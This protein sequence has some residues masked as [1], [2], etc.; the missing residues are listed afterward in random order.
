[1]TVNAVCAI[2]IL[3]SG[4]DKQRPYFVALALLNVI[5]FLFHWCS[6]SLH[7]ATNV[8]DAV[9]I[10]KLHLL[11]IILGHPFLILVLGLW[12]RFKYVNAL[13]YTWCLLSLPL[14]F[15]NIFSDFS[16]RYGENVELV[17]YQTIFGDYASVLKGEGGAYFP[18]IHLSYGL[19]SLFMMYC[20]VRFFKQKQTYLFGALLLTIILQFG[21]SVVGFQIDQQNLNW[22][23]VGGV[24]ST[25][26]SLLVLG[27][28]SRGFKEKSNELVREFEQKSALQHV[29][30]ELAQI[31]NEDGQHAFY[32]ESVELLTRYTKADYVLFG[33]VDANDAQKI[34]T[35]VAFK[36]GVRIE[37]FAYDR[38]G[39]PCEN[40]LSIDA[41]VH[42][43]HVADDYPDDAFLREEGIEAYIGYPIVGSKQCT[44]GVLV[45][46]YKTPLQNDATVKTVTDVFAT[47]ISAEIRRQILQDELRAT[48]YIDYLTRLPNRIKLLRFINNIRSR[49]YTDH[50]QALLMLFDIDH[51]GEVNRKYG[52]DVGDRVLKV[53]GD[54]LQSYSNEGVFISRCGGDEFAVVIPDIKADIAKV[55]NVHWTAI[56]AIVSN[57]C[58]IGNRRININ[59]TM[60]AVVFPSQLDSSFDVIGA[61]EQAMMVSKEQGRGRFSFFDPALLMDVEHARELEADLV[62][63]LQSEDG[64]DVFYQPKVNRDGDIVGAEALVRWFSKKRGFV[65]PAEFIPVAEETGVIH[66]LG[67]WVVE[68]VLDDM[69]RWQSAGLN[70]VP[71]AINATASQFEDSEFIQHLM[72]S[73]ESR[74]ISPSLIELELTE[75]GLLTERH[76]AIATLNALRSF[77]IAVALDDFGTGYSSLSY[78]SELP[79]DVLKI[80]KSFVDGLHDERNRELVKSI[81]AISKAMD[82]TNVAEGT[83]T[84]EQVELM[85]SYG[86]TLFQGYYFSKPLA[87]KD[88]EAWLSGAE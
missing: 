88:F 62:A 1:M 64:L 83:E 27:M 54:R 49:F 57:T 30:A 39:T 82:L 25:V 38:K 81:I 76:K 40:V 26:L 44:I 74:E 51:F 72:T 71:V 29:F 79:L 2:S 78:L 5:L 19:S 86:C 13:F 53:L 45:L 35:K 56:Q 52:Y 70:V 11:C 69:A 21:S 47:R 22:V 77:G 4:I 28:I 36:D 10:S 17:S 7:S 14:L 55:T 50:N 46:L 85:A 68:R 65:S 66:M 60:G 31:S 43:S 34:M 41:C 48:A 32:E 18:L 37:N 84:L 33:L 73:I 75:S 87:K 67:K 58:E 61:A 20:V 15:I 3:L 16:I 63:A 80:D 24:P 12:T 8:D 23:Y 9:F 6:L 59:C 42:Q